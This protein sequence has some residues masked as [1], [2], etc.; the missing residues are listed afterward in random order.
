MNIWI[1]IADIFYS[2]WFLVF[3]TAFNNIS[4]ISWH[5][6]LLVE[7][8]EVLGENHWPVAS[9]WQTLSHNVISSTPRHDDPLDFSQ[10]FTKWE[11]FFIVYFFRVYLHIVRLKKKI[12]SIV[13]AFSLSTWL[14]ERNLTLNSTL[15][16]P[17]VD[18]LLQDLGLID[19]MDSSSLC[20]NDAS[21]FDSTGSDG[22]NNG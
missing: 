15:S 13:V 9:H 14:S 16:D 11:K 8:T 21:P 7:E 17:Q 6:L 3:N 5:S 18:K 20:D 10:N 2:G 19:F 4:V 22:W 1:R 12:L